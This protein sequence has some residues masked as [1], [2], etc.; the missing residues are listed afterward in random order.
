M[1]WREAADFEGEVL[2]QDW[3]FARLGF[4]TSH[5]PL[6]TFHPNLAATGA[7]LGSCKI[8]NFPFSIFHFPF[9]SHNARLGCFPSTFGTP[10]P[11]LQR[12]M[13]NGKMENPNLAAA[14]LG[15]LL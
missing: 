4:S 13:E 7:R 1:S 2:R 11:L 10:W 14:R 6:P 8:G 12:M 9:F 15:F 5:F 3:A